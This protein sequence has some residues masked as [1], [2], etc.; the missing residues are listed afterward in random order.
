MVEYPSE[1]P[2]TL[3]DR[4]P[5]NPFRPVFP[6][7]LLDAEN[8]EGTEDV[9]SKFSMDDDLRGDHFAFIR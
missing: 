4:Y 7:T 1:A 9:R 6:G 5:W 2:S 3:L 8:A